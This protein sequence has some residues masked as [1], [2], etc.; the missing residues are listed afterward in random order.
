MANTQEITFSSPALHV[1]LTD[2]GVYHVT[3]EGKGD[4]LEFTR[5]QLIRHGWAPVTG[6]SLRGQVTIWWD[7]R[8]DL[9]QFIDQRARK[10][11]L[12]GLS[13]VVEE[14]AFLYIS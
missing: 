3:R 2:A 13:A 5:Y 7:R 4:Y 14:M 8:E 9:A 11:T 12:D 10:S 6:S 1:E